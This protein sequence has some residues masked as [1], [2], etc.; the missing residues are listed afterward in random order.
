MS[1]ECLISYDKKLSKFFEYFDKKA[2]LGWSVRREK[3]SM[4]FNNI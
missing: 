1:N 4:I 2:I 3:F